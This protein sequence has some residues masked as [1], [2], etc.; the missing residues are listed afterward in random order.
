MF[1]TG[2]TAKVP[3]L[4]TTDRTTAHDPRSRRNAFLPRL[5]DVLVPV[6]IY[7]GLRRAGAGN[8]LALTAGAFVPA[9][10]VLISIVR[11][12]RVAGLAA[13]VLGVFALSIALAFVTGNAHLVL[14]KESVFTML[15]GVYCL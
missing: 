4:S 11:D 14:A 6:G 13:F 15:A 3:D 12:R 5:V 2:R 1:P 7:F 9:L 10:R 8:V